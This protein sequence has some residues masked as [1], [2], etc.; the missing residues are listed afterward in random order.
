MKICEI[1][2]S[3]Q[4][5]GADNGFPTVF[6]RCSGC[7]LRCSYC[8]TRHAWQ[9]GEELSRDAILKRIAAW[10]TRRALITGGEPLLQR[11]A[12]VGLMEALLDSG[13]RVLLETNGSWPVQDLPEA[14]ISII[15]VKTPG[16]GMSGVNNLE[17]LR[18]ARRKQDHF[19]FVIC[20]EEDFLWAEKLVRRYRL[21]TRYTC[22]FSPAHPR[23]DST[24]LAERIL[25]S[26]LDIR[27]NLQLHKILWPNAERGR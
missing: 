8:D 25:Q 7:N 26:D 24:W 20:G 11:E 13:Y 27:L 3:I 9:D 23:T 2:H 14:V 1:F 19:K 6:V 5:E 4:G 18:R 21:A 17:N 12:V 15:D 10:P 16:S 22:H